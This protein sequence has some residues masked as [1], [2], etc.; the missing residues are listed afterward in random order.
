M[1]HAD[2]AL[3]F[4][5]SAVQRLQHAIQGLD[6]A[7][8]Q[9]AAAAGGL[10]VHAEAPF[11]SVALSGRPRIVVHELAS[12]DGEI[13]MRA[14]QAGRPGKVSPWGRD[15]MQLLD[16]GAEISD[17]D[18]GQ[19]GISDEDRQKYEYAPSPWPWACSPVECW[20]PQR[21]AHTCNRSC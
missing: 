16:D 2:R 8:P 1:D 19:D 12:D 17:S 14:T 4:C 18:A 21:S 5:S 7:R 20:H 11:A 13:H 10:G 3:Q 9:G 15:P 6:Q